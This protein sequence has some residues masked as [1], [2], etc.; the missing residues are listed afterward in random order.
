MHHKTRSE[1]TIAFGNPDQ[2]HEIAKKCLNRII[3]F[4]TP[5][6]PEVYEVWYRY[7]EGHY[8]EITRKLNDA[9]NVVHEVSLEGI[10]N[11]RDQHLRNL[12]DASVNIELTCRLAEESVSLQKLAENQLSLM[13]N[14]EESLTSCQKKLDEPSLALSEVKP[15]LNQLLSLSSNATTLA[16]NFCESLTSVLGAIERLN[17][18]VF[19]LQQRLDTDPLTGIGNRGAFEKK[20]S[21][22]N[23][24]DP[25][26]RRFMYLFLIDVDDFKRIND[27]CGHGS[28][29]S[30]LRSIADFLKNI[31]PDGTVSRFGG[32]EFAIVAKIESDGAIAL[33]NKIT[34]HFSS[35]DTQSDAHVIDGRVV[36]VSAGA[37]R[38]RSDDTSKS[39]FDR[40]DRLLYEA[41]RAGKNR[42]MIEKES[43]L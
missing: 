35:A 14:F 34:N 29:D 6:F 24:I 22:G 21:I 28:G 33:A 30:I 43:A 36:A 26:E 39:W 25:Y 5:P 19:L 7:Y 23:S 3:E 38:L 8:P 18:E 9:M 31:S 16:S 11:L 41:K 12:N 27:T 10:L 4:K 42:V 13:Q 37:A 40:A 15:H 2:A 32:D 1:H 20:L 17:A